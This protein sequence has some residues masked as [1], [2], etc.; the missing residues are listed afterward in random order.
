MF[1][2]VD[3]GSCL[4]LPTDSHLTKPDRHH[5][6]HAYRSCD[7]LETAF[8]RHVYLGRKL[9]TAHEM[10]HD[11]TRLRLLK[12]PTGYRQ[13]LLSTCSFFLVYTLLKESGSK[14]LYITHAIVFSEFLTASWSRCPRT[15]CA[16]GFH[17]LC[18]LRAGILG[19]F[20]SI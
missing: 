2:Y 10:C 18:D 13:D 15:L 14:M 16:S 6:P 20:L 3:L 7:H 5:P 12:S 17:C 4:L 9:Y 11:C 8:R 1:V 19:T